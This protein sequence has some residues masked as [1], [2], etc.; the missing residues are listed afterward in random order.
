MSSKEQASKSLGE[1]LGRRVVSQ[2]R[3]T[4]ALHSTAARRQGRAVLSLVTGD[5]RCRRTRETQ[6]RGTGSLFCRVVPQ[7][8]KTG[9]RSVACIHCMM[10]ILLEHRSC[11]G[12]MATYSRITGRKCSASYNSPRIS[13]AYSRV[14]GWRCSASCV[15][16]TCLVST[17]AN[18]REIVCDCKNNMC[19]CISTHQK[20]FTRSPPPY[21]HQ[22]A[23]SALAAP[24]CFQKSS[25]EPQR[26]Q[27]LSSCTLSPDTPLTNSSGRGF[28][29]AKAC[30]CV[31]LV[32]GCQHIKRRTG[33]AVVTPMGSDS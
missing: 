12:G 4:V 19:I 21:V 5:W 25:H 30:I 29:T 22:S 6:V 11:Y 26:S 3:D 7:Q 10:I 2:S 9:Y 23:V 27:Q 15:D 16:A 18:E 33:Q 1:V 28:V 31:S 20:P 13:I 14:R 17:G 32:K 24:V 8:G